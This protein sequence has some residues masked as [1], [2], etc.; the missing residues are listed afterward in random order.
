MK[1]TVHIG[2]VEAGDEEVVARHFADAI[3]ALP[4]SVIG[5]SKVRATLVEGPKAKAA[6]KEEAK[7]SPKGKK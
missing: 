4:K 2:D 3:Y 6:P 5:S 1:L 7:A